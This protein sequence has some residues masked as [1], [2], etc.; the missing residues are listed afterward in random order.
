M[1]RTWIL[2]LVVVAGTVACA[3]AQGSYL[4][5]ALPALAS[6]EG[7]WFYAG[8]PRQPCY[9]EMDRGGFRGPR[10][11]FTNERGEQTEGRLLEDGRRVLANNWGGGNLVGDVRR[12]TIEWR[13]GTTWTRGERR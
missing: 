3:E 5:K 13:N 6:L 9:I 7:Q 8:D 1:Y 10:L 4:P 12:N 11:I 2:A